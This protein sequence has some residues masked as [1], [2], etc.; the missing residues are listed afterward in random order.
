LSE[1]A[2]AADPGL[3]VQ[4]GTEAA[5]QQEVSSRLSA[6]RGAPVTCREIGVAES[7]HPI[8]GYVVGSGP[9]KVSLIGGS[10]ADEPVG[11]ETLRTFIRTA[12]T[13]PEKISD[14]LEKYTFVIVAH[15]NPDGESANADWI[16]RWPSIDGYLKQVERELPG[17]D[18]EFGYPDM[19]YENEAVVQFLREQAPFDLHMSLHSMSF[20]DG[21][22]LLIE[23][24]WIDR[25]GGIQEAFKALAKEHGF[26]LHDH[27]RGGEKGFEYIGPG[28]TT[29]PEGGRMREYFEK[30]RELTTAKKFKDSSM[31]FVR[32]LGGDPLCL[33]TELPL[34]L[35]TKV[36]ADEPKGD[37]QT[38]L[39]LKAHLPAAKRTATANQSIDWFIDR[40]GLE[41]IPAADAIRFQL[42]VIEIG[43]DAIA[44]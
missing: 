8:L 29:T 5:F 23:R 31:E 44:S 33:V 14:Y 40:Y 18:I 42:G 38:Y 32:S 10:H 21:A 35:I 17:R 19:R 25:S 15:V 2:K 28:F 26:R 37:P 12:I 22:L 7:G 3:F 43:L 16:K 24:S 41:A 9:K 27:D 1:L 39:K 6:T 36:G 13:S 30:R 20:S 34:F 4:F 11:P